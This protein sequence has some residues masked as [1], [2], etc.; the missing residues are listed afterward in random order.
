MLHGHASA[1]ASAQ[2]DLCT[3]GIPGVIPP[4]FI[5]TYCCA[6]CKPTDPPTPVPP[7]TAAVEPTPAPTGVPTF[8]PTP[9]ATTPPLPVFDTAKEQEIEAEIAAATVV[10]INTAAATDF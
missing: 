10:V 9:A 7:T 3:E 4:G 6:S 1:S 8:A 2:L 5:A